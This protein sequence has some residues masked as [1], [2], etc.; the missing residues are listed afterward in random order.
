[1]DIGDK[2]L[3]FTNTEDVASMYI[4]EVTD[5]YEIGINEIAYEISTRFFK[6]LFC[7]DVM[8]IKKFK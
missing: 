6:D 1:M 5:A 3:M 7:D 2:K 4:I 8:P